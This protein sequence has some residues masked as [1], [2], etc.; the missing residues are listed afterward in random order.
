M[1]GLDE[2]LDEEQ[3]EEALVDMFDDLVM[4]RQ[5]GQ[6]PNWLTEEM[7]NDMKQLAELFYDLIAEVETMKKTNAGLFLAN[8]KSKIKRLLIGDSSET[9]ADVKQIAKAGAV[10]TKKLNINTC[11]SI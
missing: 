2:N 6:A 11:V 7:F 9:F 1:T 8:L 10:E 4:R 5:D 3:L